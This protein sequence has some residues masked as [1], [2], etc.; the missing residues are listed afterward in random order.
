MKA[1]SCSRACFCRL[2]A[3]P[4]DAFRS[5]DIILIQKLAPPISDVH[6]AVRNNCLDLGQR[7]RRTFSIQRRR[8]G[9]PHMAV[10]LELPHYTTEV[11]VRMAT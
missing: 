4:M 6:E 8:G 5:V 1:S 3:S 2:E 10:G 7:A 11:I 9:E